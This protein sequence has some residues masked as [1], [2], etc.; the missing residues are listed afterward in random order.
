MVRVCLP[1]RPGN[2]NS[3]FDKSHRTAISEGKEFNAFQSEGAE[4][5]LGT[6]GAHKN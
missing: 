1:K 5:P 4:G 6:S 2:L 3:T